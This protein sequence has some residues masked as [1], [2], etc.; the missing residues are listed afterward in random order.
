MKASENRT[1]MRVLPDQGGG[2][3]V[4]IAPKGRLAALLTTW[5]YLRKMGKRV[6]V[7]P[8]YSNLQTKKLY[9][10]VDNVPIA[11]AARCRLFPLLITLW[12]LA[13][14]AAVTIHVSPFASLCAPTR[15]LK[16]YFYRSFSNLTKPPRLLLLSL[17]A[18]F[19]GIYANKFGDTAN[20][21]HD[22][23]REGQRKGIY[24]D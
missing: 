9:S 11:T 24:R 6:L 18:S 20:L 19:A 23:R 14:V 22:L 7:R 21:A 17:S 2:I 3:Q 12:Q 8:L 5:G 1:E 4:E 15:H 16:Q 13:S 10:K